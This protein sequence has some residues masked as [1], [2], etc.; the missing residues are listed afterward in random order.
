MFRFAFLSSFFTD[1][2]LSHIFSHFVYPPFCHAYAAFA[3]YAPYDVIHYAA[4]LSYAMPP[5]DILH[6]TPATIRQSHAAAFLL[7]TLC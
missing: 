2:S 7:P 6:I 4:V 1:I 3:I 5:E